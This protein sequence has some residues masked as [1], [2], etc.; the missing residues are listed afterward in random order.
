MDIRCVCVCVCVCVHAHAY[1]VWVRCI[2]AGTSKNSPCEDTAGPRYKKEVAEEVVLLL[3]PYYVKKN[4]ESKVVII[5][6]PAGVFRLCLFQD[7][8]KQ[9]ARRVSQLFLSWG[10]S[11]HASK[12]ALK[13]KHS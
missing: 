2:Q 3:N 6:G 7:L 5:E 13:R 11:N 10:S 9:I 8:F 4:I 12:W 1:V